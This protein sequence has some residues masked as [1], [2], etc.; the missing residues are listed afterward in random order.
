MI[1]HP[2]MLLCLFFA[3]RPGAVT[4]Q[5]SQQPFIFTLYGGLFFPSTYGFAD[6]YH[7]NSDLIWGVGV[8]LPVS[9]LLDITADESFFKTNA[10]IDPALDSSAS[11]EEHFI[12]VGILVKQPLM[13]LIS[14]RLSG[15]LNYVSVQQTIAGPSTPQ[16][17][18][19][20]PK[21]V[22]YYGGAGIEELVPDLHLSFFCDLV[23]DYRR[24]YQQDLD[25]DFGGVRAVLGVNLI[26]F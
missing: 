13:Q 19:S 22:G 14:L 2:M 20:A 1:K 5:S 12:H 18:V 10:F 9:A 24:L 26:L 8:A 7:S 6:R 25:G 3:L 16:S 15:G 11:L 4:A 17:T 23:Y 21:K